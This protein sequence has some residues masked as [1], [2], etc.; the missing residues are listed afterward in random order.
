MSPIIMITSR[1]GEKHRQRAMDLGDAALPRQTVPGSR[2]D[3]QRVRTAQGRTR[4]RQF[5]VVN[6][7]ARRAADL[8][9]DGARD[10]TEQRSPKRART[11]LRC[12]IPRGVRADVRNAAPDA[13]LV[14]PDPA[15]GGRCRS[16]TACWP[17]RA[18]DHV[19][20]ADVAAKR[21]GWKPRA[22]RATSAPS[23]TATTTPLPREG[24]SPWWPTRTSA[25]A[26]K[27]S[28]FPRRDGGICSA[29]RGDA[30]TVAWP[31]GCAAGEIGRSGGRR[32][33]RRS[34]A[35]RR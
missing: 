1:T 12:S 19:R 25:S 22:G 33:R 5:G 20:E 32:R 10:R 13:V 27:T 4:G 16:S 7:E 15:T 18:G 34:D 30:G 17:I 9:P 23:C 31:P 21:E 29:G 26:A 6:H 35:V 8:P 14:I 11:W 2:A 24:L 3:A 28:R